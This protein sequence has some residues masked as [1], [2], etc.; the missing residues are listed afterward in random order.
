M[1]RDDIQP[2][3]FSVLSLDDPA[4]KVCQH[5]GARL[6]PGETTT[7][8]QKGT[9]AL[10]PLP[11][12]PPDV[13]DAT[14]SQLTQA[15]QR[16]LNG[17]LAFTA[18]ASSRSERTPSMWAHPHTGVSSFKVAGRVYHRVFDA[19]APYP[20]EAVPVTNLA[21]IYLTGDQ[22]F[23]AAIRDNRAPIEVPGHVLHV[24]RQLL[25]QHNLFAR[26]Y[27]SATQSL[28]EQG[29]N[30]Q[31]AG[32]LF[33]KTSRATHGSV[34]GDAPTHEHIAAVVFARTGTSGQPWKRQ[35]VTYLPSLPDHNK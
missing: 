33:Q 20:D 2:Y 29:E 4:A 13:E 26:S 16:K 24:W 35:T 32:L 28:R 23:E 19:Y 27:R 7:C 17:L 10:E 12:L 11:P 14:K 34:L 21:R 30:A 15:H 6:W 18:A 31:P 8:C 3:R 25:F 5:C 22:D 1:A 9:K